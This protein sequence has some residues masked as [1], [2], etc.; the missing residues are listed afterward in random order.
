METC[1][2]SRFL[3]NRQQG[4]FL[5]ME[6]FCLLLRLT[7]AHH[8]GEKLGEQIMDGCKSKKAERAKVMDM[9]SP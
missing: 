7:V 6:L 1:Y 4:Y 8:Q 2:S 3:E 9:C 5:V